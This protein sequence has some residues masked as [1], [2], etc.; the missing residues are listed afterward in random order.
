MVPLHE[1]RRSAG[2]GVYSVIHT[3]GATKNDGTVSAADWARSR[4]ALP[5]AAAEGARVKVV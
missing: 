4:V 2:G 1:H 5:A 3:A